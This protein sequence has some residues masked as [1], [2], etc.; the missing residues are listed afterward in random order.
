M[1]ISGY[2]VDLGGYKKIYTWSRPQSII[3]FLRRIL[4]DPNVYG[5]ETAEL[6]STEAD[7]DGYRWI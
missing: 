7:I 3:L 5:E 2:K 6:I 4:F 1:D